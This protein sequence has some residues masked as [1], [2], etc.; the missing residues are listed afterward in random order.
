MNSP[1]A[2][3]R[4]VDRR[5]QASANRTGMPLSASMPSRLVLSA[6]AFWLPAR[7]SVCIWVAE[8]SSFWISSSSSAPDGL[9][10]FAAHPSRSNASNRAN[11]NYCLEKAERNHVV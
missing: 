8:R 10:I 7:A 3:M 5:D 11:L 4:M 9:R 2:K 1:N 6:T